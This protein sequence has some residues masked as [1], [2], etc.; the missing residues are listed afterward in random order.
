MHLY[1][2]IKTANN[3]TLYTE[4]PD[5]RSTSEKNTFK[6]TIL[7]KNP[8]GDILEKIYS[9]ETIEN[10][11]VEIDYQNTITDTI[12]TDILF[13]SKSK[14]KDIENIIEILTGKPILTIGDTEGYAHKGVLINFYIEDR[15]VRFEINETAVKK[16]GFI[17]DFRLLSFAR[18][19]HPVK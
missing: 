18:I 15:K 9:T 19:V 13:I 5:D 16:A 2:I 11:K 3:F 10:K 1:N 6:I 8:F 14:Q 17:M 12:E 7:G 4:W